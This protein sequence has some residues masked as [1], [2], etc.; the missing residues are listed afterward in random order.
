MQLTT[1]SEEDT[2]KLGQ[3]IG[4]L[5]EP[6]L[7][8]ALYG[9][10][11]T[12]KTVLVRGLARGLGV[13]EQ[14]PITSPTFTLINEYT[15]RLLLFHADL[16]RIG[17]CADLEEIGFDEIFDGKNVV[18]VEWAE[19]CQESLPSDRLEIR[20]RDQAPKIRLLSLNACGQHSEDLLKALR[21]HFGAS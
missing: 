12:G 7:V 17:H 9:D 10:L 5:A 6:G 18:A 1:R 3:L 21:K 13:T 11:G 4:K 16:Y 8:L 20:F 15:G 2:R 14:T 19:H